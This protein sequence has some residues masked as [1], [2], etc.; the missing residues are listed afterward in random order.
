MCHVGRKSRK[1]LTQPAGPHF[2][3]HGHGPIGEIKQRVNQAEI[4]K[5]T[6]SPNSATY[7]VSSFIII[8]SKKKNLFF[9]ISLRHV[10]VL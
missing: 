4:K 6:E 3:A 2:S 7:G 10:D 5:E 1:F 9:F 8:V